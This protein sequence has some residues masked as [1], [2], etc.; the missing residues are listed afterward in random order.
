[1]VGGRL[2][3]ARPEKEGASG[4]MFYEGWNMKGKVNG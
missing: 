2:N 3:A 4:K 1:V